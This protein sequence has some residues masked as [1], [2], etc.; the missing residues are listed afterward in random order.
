MKFL[1]VII[2]VL[3]PVFVNAAPTISSISGSVSDSQSITINGTNFGSGPN[4]V[5][6]DDFNGGTTGATIPLSSGKI[7]AWDQYRNDGTFPPIYAPSTHGSSAMQSATLGVG[8]TRQIRKYFASCTEAFVSYWTRIPTGTTYPGTESLGVFDGGSSWKL[9]WIWRGNNGFND[10]DYMLGEYNGGWTNSTNADYT[11]NG[12]HENFWYNAASPRVDTWWQEDAGFNRWHRLSI[13]LKAGTNPTADVGKITVDAI[14][15]DTKHVLALN[16][17]LS[18]PLFGAGV[19][20][21]PEYNTVAFPGNQSCGTNCA[22]VYDDI[23]IATGPNAQARVEIGNASTYISS[24]NLAIATPTSWGPS[25]ITATIRAGSF[26]S[27]NVYVYVTDANGVV[28]TTG[29]G[30]ITFAG[31]QGDTT[32]PIVSASPDSNSSASLTTVTLA[33]NETATIYYTLDG[34][35]P[36][37]S[38]PTYSAPLSIKPGTTLK[39]FG[40]DEALNESTVQTSQYKWRQVCR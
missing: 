7:G 17:N 16:N 31:S 29:Y 33:A 15:E 40:V 14:E 30:P 2:I 38:S 3:L 22:P 26:T 21:T 25:S 35:T 13:W 6:F 34:S 8:A 27:G 19:G 9:A 18:G 10:H 23:Y 11:S 20:T 12:G 36:T 32:P 4:V 1:L 28:N 5:L 24:T 37:T 39:Y